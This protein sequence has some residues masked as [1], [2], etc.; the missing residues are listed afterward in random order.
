LP[1]EFLE[2]SQAGN[3]R[4]RAVAAWLPLLACVFALAAVPAI[5]Q[6]A[7]PGRSADWALSEPQLQRVESGAIIAEGDVAPDKPIVDVRAAIKIAAPPEKVFRTLTDCARALHFVPHLKRCTV[8]ESAPDGHWQNVEQTVDY[9]LLIPRK[10]YVFHAEYET[11][12]RIRFSNL[13][14][15]FREN[16]GVWTFRPLDDGRA[17]VVT[18]EARVAPAFYAPRWMMRNM[19]KRDLPD[20]MRGLKTHAEAVRSAAAT[21][22]GVAGVP[23]DP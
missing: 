2:L 14:G 15:D 22:A 17:T 7:E 21:N 3:R 1:T 16:R 6:S 5:C 9:G 18:Y 8:L 11:F 23:P 19:L 20:L 4:K 13:R 10:S 12:T